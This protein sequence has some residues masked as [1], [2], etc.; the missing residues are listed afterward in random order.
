MKTDWLIKLR[1]LLSAKFVAF[2][3]NDGEITGIVP[4]E[5]PDELLSRIKV[6]VISTVKTSE[7]LKQRVV[8]VLCSSLSQRIALCPVKANDKDGYL[9]VGM[10][11]DFDVLA[12]K[13]VL[14][15][16]SDIK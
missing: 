3:M 4:N 11:E 13:G 8:E 2:A 5:I 9:V 15:S 6:L 14:N 16:L 12:M 7:L 10:R 1:E